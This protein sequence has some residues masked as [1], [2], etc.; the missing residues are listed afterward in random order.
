M[1]AYWK[2][3]HL[4]SQLANDIESQQPPQG[5]R[6][7]PFNYRTNRKVKEATE[8]IQA[9]G[10]DLKTEILKKKNELKQTIRHPEISEKQR[11]NR[12]RHEREDKEADREFEENEQAKNCQRR[13]TIFISSYFW[14]LLV[15]AVFALGAMVLAGIVMWFSRL[16]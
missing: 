16:A 6:T 2:K 1:A 10:R 8:K 14:A 4:P 7:E 15:L 12:E 13:S 11:L 5:P 9:H 3:K